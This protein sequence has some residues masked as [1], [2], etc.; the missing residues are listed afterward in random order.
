VFARL[1]GQSD[2]TATPL[3]LGDTVDLTK[4]GIAISV[5]DL[6]EKIDLS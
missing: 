6:S 2:W 4:V 1:D 5:V 3:V